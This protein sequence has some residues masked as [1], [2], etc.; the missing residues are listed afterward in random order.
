MHNMVIL[1]NFH[2]QITKG[3][4]Y[5]VFDDLKLLNTEQNSCNLSI[6]KNQC[7]DYR[8]GGWM[9]NKVSVPCGLVGIGV[10]FESA[11]LTGH[12]FESL[13]SVEVSWS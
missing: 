1:D 2:S 7:L 3:S 11:G 10:T 9:L 5:I 4:K 12:R 6:N 8:G 13:N